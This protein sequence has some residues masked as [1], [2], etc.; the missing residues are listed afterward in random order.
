M[1][2]SYNISE[3]PMA[4][5]LLKLAQLPEPPPDS[6]EAPAPE[7]HGIKSPALHA[8]KAVGAGL[9]GT[10]VGMAAGYGAHM[11]LE[12]LFSKSVTPSRMHAL[13]PVLGGLA[14]LSYHMF[15]DR[16]SKELHRALESHQNQRAAGSSAK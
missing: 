6:G 13:A 9:L 11:G 2:A 1:K 4:R 3:F 12:R 16:E 7:L 8:A 5:E 10:G 14:G 15:K